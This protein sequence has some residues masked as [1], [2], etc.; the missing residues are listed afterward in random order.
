MNIN[1]V[2]DMI[3]NLNTN[4]WRSV[5]HHQ[6]H[7]TMKW[8]LVQ[9]TKCILFSS[10]MWHIWGRRS[11]AAALILYIYT[12]NIVRIIPHTHTHRTKQT[13]RKFQLCLFSLSSVNKTR[14]K[15]FFLSGEDN[16]LIIWNIMMI[17][18]FIV[19]SLK[20]YIYCRVYL[21][22]QFYLYLFNIN[23]ATVWCFNITEVRPLCFMR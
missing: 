13:N 16:V 19:S 8:W 23:F 22:Y 4:N 15:N 3:I 1:I 6:Y 11:L 21:G 10:N 9:E 18:N 2:L 20:F 5:Y 17:Y 14:I 12:S 7:I